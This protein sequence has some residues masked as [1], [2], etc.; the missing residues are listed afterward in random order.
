MGEFSLGE[1]ATREP[2]FLKSIVTS[3]ANSDKSRRARRCGAPM[4]CT[5]GPVGN[6]VENSVRAVD[7][8]ALGRLRH[9]IAAEGKEEEDQLNGVLRML[10]AETSDP[11]QLPLFGDGS[12]GE[13]PPN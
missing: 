3:P 11:N 2:S 1:G 5:V 13:V 7:E 6:S 8:A 4:G 9:A 12:A 10:G